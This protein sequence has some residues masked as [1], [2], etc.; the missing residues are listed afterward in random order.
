[1]S[2]VPY[3]SSLQVPQQSVAFGQTVCYEPGGSTPL[4]DVNYRNNLNLPMALTWQT[5]GL[6]NA[7]AEWQLFDRWSD[8]Q[9]G[10]DYDYEISTGAF[11]TVQTTGFLVEQAG[12]YKAESTLHLK[13]QSTDSRNIAMQIGR[14]RNGTWERVG[15]PTISGYI[16]MNNSNE[17]NTV[18]VS[19][20]Q[21]IISTIVCIMVN[22]TRMQMII[23]YTELSEIMEDGKTSKWSLL[24]SGLVRLN[25]KLLRVSNIGLKF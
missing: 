24:K 9:T 11:F 14:K 21:R 18:T 7:D 6:P 23:T 19:I 10:S 2:G 22:I 25:V 8:F 12:Y 17:S 3:S 13:S 4:I 15:T 1:M 5:T 16:K 20:S